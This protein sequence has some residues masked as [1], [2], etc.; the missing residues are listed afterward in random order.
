MFGRGRAEL[1][2]G[3]CTGMRASCLGRRV[4]RRA[5]SNMLDAGSRYSCGMSDG[6]RLFGRTG[7]LG[8]CVLCSGMLRCCVLRSRVLRRGLT[9]CS[10]LALGGSLTF[11]GCLVLRSGLGL[12][13]SVLGRLCCSF[14]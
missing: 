13:S 4:M 10:S 3:L 14:D 7:M 2:G 11:C 9:L 8:G 6:G 5:R 12:G 1:V